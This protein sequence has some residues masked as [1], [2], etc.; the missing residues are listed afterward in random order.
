VGQDFK[1]GIFRIFDESTNQTDGSIDSDQRA[2]INAD[3]HIQ[4]QKVAAFI[5]RKDISPGRKKSIFLTSLIVLLI[6]NCK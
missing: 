5:V 1:L 6:N 4:V 3:D 2:M